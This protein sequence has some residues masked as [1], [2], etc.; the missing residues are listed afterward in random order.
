M[1]NLRPQPASKETPENVR[2]KRR[3]TGRTGK[4]RPRRLD[5]GAEIEA[6]EHNESYVSRLEIVEK[7][8]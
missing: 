1:E 3:L 2:T 7:L 5:V 8:N 4:R 6:R